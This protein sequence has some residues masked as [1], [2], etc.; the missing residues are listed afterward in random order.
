ME[1]GVLL[2]VLVLLYHPVL[3]LLNHLQQLGVILFVEHNL[4]EVLVYVHVILVA[5]LV[6]Q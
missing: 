5:I 6:V 4:M 3:V 1:L 2:L